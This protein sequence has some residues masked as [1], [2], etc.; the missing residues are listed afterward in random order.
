MPVSRTEVVT[1]ACCFDEVYHQRL[2]QVDV[3]TAE[4]QNKVK[5]KYQSSFS[6]RGQKAKL[7]K[8]LAKGEELEG[9]KWGHFE[10]A[11]PFFK[12]ILLRKP[13]VNNSPEWPSSQSCSPD[14]LSSTHPC[15]TNATFGLLLL[16]TLVL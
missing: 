7:T 16:P 8:V 11:A 15:L 6:F 13:Q 3:G 5:K 1:H 10:S 2:W 4:P 9:M 12:Q 14:L